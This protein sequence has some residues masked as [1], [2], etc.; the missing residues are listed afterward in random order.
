MRGSISFEFHLPRWATYG[1]TQSG[2]T[3]LMCMLPVCCGANIRMKGCWLGGRI[4][5]VAMTESN[6]VTARVWNPRTCRTLDTTEQ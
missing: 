6:S 4:L 3:Y 5:D 2:A 1:R